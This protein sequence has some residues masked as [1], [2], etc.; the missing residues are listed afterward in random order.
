MKFEL[1]SIWHFIYMF[2][3][4]II[5][6]MI[7]FLSYNK[8]E[9]TKNIIGDIKQSISLFIIIIRNIDI[10]LRS[11]WNIEVIRFFNL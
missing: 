6:I 4:F 3:P 5:F 1:W 10:F 2:S 8:S 9:K 7:Y 11:D